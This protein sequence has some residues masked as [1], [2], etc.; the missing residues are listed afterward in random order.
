MANL[1]TPATAASDTSTPIQRFIREYAHHS[2]KGNVPELIACFADVFLA[3]GQQGAK[4]VRASDFALALP[5]RYKLFE[6][7]GCRSTEL[8]GL[9]ENWLDTR[10][11]SVRTEWRLTFVRPSSQPLPIEVESTYL[12]DAGV[13]PFRI[14]VYLAHSDIMEILMQ[15]GI[16]PV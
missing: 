12:V 4:P 7:M 6:S 11:V 13:A 15:N 3:A 16:A 1:D 10:H 2:D 9:H 8:T 5:K 14:L